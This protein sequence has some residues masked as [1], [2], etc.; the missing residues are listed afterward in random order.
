MRMIALA[1]AVCLAVLIGV[2][3]AQ[4]AAG[5]WRRSMPNSA[6]AAA[7][8]TLGDSSPAAFLTATLSSRLS[9]ASGAL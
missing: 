4:T 1:A 5:D 8:P 2:P 6:T 9:S 7:N 3:A